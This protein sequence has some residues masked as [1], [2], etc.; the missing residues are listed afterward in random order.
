MKKVVYLL[1]APEFIPRLRLQANTLLECGYRVTAIGWDRRN[2]HPK[3]E[4]SGGVRYLRIP[5]YLDTKGI[6]KGQCQAAMT[7]WGI[8]G[9]RGL[10]ML[11]MM[12]LV[13]LNCLKALRKEDPDTIHCT[14]VSLLP[15]AALVGKASK[16][17]VIYEVSDFYIFQS[18]ERL[19][20]AFGFIEKV[21][22]S[23]A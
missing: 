20:K 8:P 5:P 6:E 4:T 3:E 12:P 23:N 10:R 1:N 19:P 17:K 21:S 7:Y 11:K 15:L 16:K 13:Y 18:F 9:Q 14:H 2:T 22:R